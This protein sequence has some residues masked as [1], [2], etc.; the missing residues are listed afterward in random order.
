MCN[1]KSVLIFSFLVMSCND[2]EEMRKIVRDSKRNNDNAQWSLIEVKQENEKLLKQRNYYCC[3][4]H[5][6]I[7]AN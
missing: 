2:N 6:E 5:K 3:D 7:K 4:L 1:L